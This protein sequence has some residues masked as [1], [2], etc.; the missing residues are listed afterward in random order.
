MVAA[1]VALEPGRHCFS[2]IVDSGSP[3]RVW[4]ESKGN[5]VLPA[6]QPLLRTAGQVETAP[7]LKSTDEV[8]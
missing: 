5:P 7:S 6:S 8:S 3:G 2:R 4:A 1:H